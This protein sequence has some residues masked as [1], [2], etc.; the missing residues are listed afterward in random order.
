MSTLINAAPNIEAPPVTKP[1]PVETI[2]ANPDEP[3]GVDREIIEE[4]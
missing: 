2:P 1:T 4:I 3:F